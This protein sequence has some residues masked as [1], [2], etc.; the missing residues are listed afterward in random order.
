MNKINEKQ[1]ILLS[2][3]N[4]RIYVKNKQKFINI[5]RGVDLKIKRG[6]II[7]IV[8]ESGSGKSV[9]TKSLLDINPQ[10]TTV[11]DEAVFYG[12]TKTIDL[13]NLKDFNNI[14]GSKIGYIPQ[15]P[16]SSLNPTRKIWK[17]MNDVLL[18][19]RKDLTTKLAR[20]TYIEN[21]LTQFGIRDAH[22]VIKQYPHVLSGGM[23]QR[24]VIAMIVASRPEL[25]IADEPTTA[26][27]TTVQAAVLELLETIRQKY[28]ISIFFISHNIA[29]VAKFVDYIYVMYAGKVIE[30]GTKEE[31]LTNPKHPYTWALLSALPD[32]F[33]D[34]LESIPGHP[35]NLAH[36]PF[37]DPFAPRNQYALAIDFKKE[38][39]LFNISPTHQAATWLL[40]PKAPQIDLPLKV[41]E[42]TNRFKNVFQTIPQVATII[43]Q[44][45][46][47][48]INEK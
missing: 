8:G 28:N 25:I 6:E 32:D 7:G 33:S 13:K 27:D 12:K 10:M 17:Q 3:K 46:E 26:L 44:Q 2:V 18:L 34:T 11:S 35:P 22:Q 24:I 37:G 36:L 4:L 31:I 30:K 21:L 38:P 47:E 19:F 9:T 15:D 1:Q 5:V 42:V 43:N 41:R 29:V 48:K 40:H 20:I 16:M 14:R 45:Q 23:K 39:P